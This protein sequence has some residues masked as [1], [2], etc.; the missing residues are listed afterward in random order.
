[1]IPIEG[2]FETH[3]LV[4]DLARSVAFYRDV[5]DLPVALEIPER[6]AAFVWVGGEGA[7]MIGLWETSA[8]IG[9]HL[10]FAFSVREE[11]VIRSVDVLRAA[12]VAPL[13]FGGE[14]TDVPVV[15]GWMPAVAV[16]FRDP[17]GHSLEFISMLDAPGRPDLGLVGWP[18][19]Q[20]MMHASAL[21]SSPT[22]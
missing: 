5:L 8:P 17:D 22:R 14:P 3:L 12:G 9:M 6:R 2:I 15:L 7:A 11:D 20:E 19:W 10:H 13:G 18:D 16:Y 21:S 1:M 4:S